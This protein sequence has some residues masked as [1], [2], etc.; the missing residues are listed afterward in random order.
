MPSLIHS[1]TLDEIG[2]LCADLG[3]PAY[4]AGQIWRWLY[5]SRATD[6]ETMGNLPASLRDE[7]ARRFRLDSAVALD[8]QGKEGAT[9]KILAGLQDGECVEEVLL[10][11]GSRNTVCVSSQAGCRFRCAFCASGQAGFRRNLESGEMVGQ[12]L[13][14]AQ[15]WGQ[16]PG[17]VVFMGIGE[18]FD[19]YD[20]VLSAIR[21]INHKDGIGVGARRITI[22]TCGL[23]PGIRRLAGEGLQVELSVS[24]HAPSTELRSKL[25]PLNDRYPLAA[26]LQAC[27]DYAGTTGR[28]ATFE[29]ILIKGVNDTSS[30]AETL[31]HLLK[32]LPCRVNLIPLS[33][34]AEYPGEPSPLQTAHMFI[35]KLHESGI[36]AT[37]RDSRGASLR[38]ACGQLRYAPRPARSSS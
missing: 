25:I 6:W 31:R 16:R 7:L 33:N 19:N 11:A 4:R 8:V 35:N 36:N 5:V 24:L 10:T 3:Q 34:V 12:V 30:H 22:S 32:P 15:T 29:Y 14:A 21:I 17:N 20:A 13:L 38:A 23:I 28:I 1:L 37:L 18:P 26:L 9:R 27:R 2:T